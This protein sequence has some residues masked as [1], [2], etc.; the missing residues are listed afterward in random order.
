MERLKS[1]PTPPKIIKQRENDENK[2]AHTV[3][4]QNPNEPS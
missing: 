3:L 2:S 1:T 4:K